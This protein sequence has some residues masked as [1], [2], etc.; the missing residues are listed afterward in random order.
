MTFLEESFSAST[1]APELRLHQ[2]AA[3]A[4]LRVL[5]PATGTEIK[6]Q[7]RS[8]HELLEA[9][10]YANRPR[11][12]DDLIHILDPELRLITPTDSEG[13]TNENQTTVPSG[14]YYQL[15]HDYLV[16]SLRDWLTRKQRETR[17]GRAELRLGE[18]SSLWNAKPENRHLPS[19]LEWA[20]IRLLTG[21]KDW[22]EPQHRM[23]KRAGRVHGFRGVTTLGLLCTAVFF[24]IAVRGRVVENQRSTH[25]AGLVQRLLDADTAQVP[26]IVSAMR[27][28]RQGV[29]PALRSELERSSADSREK[30]HV[31][32]A[33]VPVDPTQVDYLF[34]RLKH[35]SPNELSV[36][37]DALKTH[38]SKLTPKLWTVLESAKPSDASLLPSAGALASYAPHDGKWEAV[39]SKVAQALV[40]V[41]AILLGPW[42]EALRPVRSKLTA[43]LA[44]VFQDKERPESEHKL[45]TNIL[46]NYASDDPD[47]LAELLMVADKKAFVSLFQVAEKRATQVLPV[48]KTELVKKATYSWSDPPLDP[49]WTEPDAALAGRIESAQGRS[50]SVSPT[51]R[52]CHW[53][54]LSRPL[55]LSANRAT[56]PCGS[57]PSRMGGLSG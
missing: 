2:K 21:K 48:L 53:K 49:S 26:D 14:Q 4:V 7:M 36:L 16:H 41:D 50:P 46:A 22:T 33:L 52:R 15:A 34:N 28:Y 45:A 32:L 37:R 54:S 8:R 19:S 40:S 6:G 25:A 24:G 47:R 12:F 18:R 10:G 5:L 1:A 57:A 23:M 31:S 39:G 51:A 13:S 55:T 3:Q 30:L 38:G 11:D 35:A 56:A 42:I 27:E 29:D 20:N 9:S 43:P 44:T 17:R